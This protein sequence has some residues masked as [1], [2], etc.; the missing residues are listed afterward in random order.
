MHA[1]GEGISRMTPLPFPVYSSI[2]QF[3]VLVLRRANTGK[4]TIL[5]W[6]CNTTES[7]TIYQRGKH[8][9]EEEVRGPNF[10]C[11]SDLT[12]QFELELSM[13]VS[14]TCTSLCLPI[15]IMPARRA[16]HRR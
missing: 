7:S 3:R 4:T 8:G 1:N 16:H 13:D 2:I 12:D 9:R 15:N 5:Q 6:V 10:V 11:E 14:D